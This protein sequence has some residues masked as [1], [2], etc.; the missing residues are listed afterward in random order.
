MTVKRPMEAAI[1]LAQF[2]W[3]IGLRCLRDVHQ[4]QCYEA[5]CMPACARSAYQHLSLL[6]ITTFGT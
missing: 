2:L 4:R 3:L 1:A 6:Q 5:E